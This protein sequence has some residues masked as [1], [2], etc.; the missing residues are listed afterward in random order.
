MKCKDNN[1]KVCF[2]TASEIFFNENVIKEICSL[3]GAESI[4]GNQLN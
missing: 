3:L 1:T 4:Q 2:I